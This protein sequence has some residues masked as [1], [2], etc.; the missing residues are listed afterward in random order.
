MMPQT[1]MEKSDKTT[2]ASRLEVSV[3]GKV[4]IGQLDGFKEQAAECIRLT[5]E[6]DRRT[7]RYDWYVSNDQTEFE[8]RESYVDSEGLMEHRANVGEA[9]DKLFRE[10]AD[11]HYVTVYGEASPQLVA[12]A[13]ATMGVRAKWYNFLQGLE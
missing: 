7:L 5:K 11:D 8:I 2:G 13:G 3:R 6:K 1:V 9:V 12:M 10:F 4:R